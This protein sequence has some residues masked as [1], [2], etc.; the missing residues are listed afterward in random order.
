[1]I[2]LSNEVCVPPFHVCPSI[3][4]CGFTRRVLG[5]GRGR[6]ALPRPAAQAR[7]SVLVPTLQGAEGHAGCGVRDG[8]AQ[9]HGRGVRERTQA[10][11]SCTQQAWLSPVSIEIFGGRFDPTGLRFPHKNP[12]MKLMPANDVRNWAAIWEMQGHKPQ[13]ASAI[14]YVS[15][16]FDCAPDALHHRRV[17]ARAA[18]ARPS[19]CSRHRLLSHIAPS[20]WATPSPYA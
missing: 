8:A 11:E 1:M 12:A 4:R 19:A 7:S 5:S 15:L 3:P 16:H 6:C 2:Q 17:K 13:F 9:R 20:R 14:R 10:V 18:S